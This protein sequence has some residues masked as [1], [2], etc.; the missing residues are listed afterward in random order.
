[1]TDMTLAE[2]DPK[3]LQQAFKSCFSTEELRDLC[4]ELAVDYEDLPAVERVWKIPGI[5]PLFS[6]TGP[7]GGTSVLCP[8]TVP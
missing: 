6:A 5:D 7:P 3:K 8:N 1:M 4:F 2:I